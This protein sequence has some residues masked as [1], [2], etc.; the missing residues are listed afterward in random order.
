MDEET[1]IKYWKQ[2]YSVKQIV[3]M[4]EVV[5]KTKDENVKNIVMNRVERVILKYQTQ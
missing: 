5:K 3:D 1:I 2:G 4:S